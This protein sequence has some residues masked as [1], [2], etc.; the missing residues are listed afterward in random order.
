M[1]PSFPRKYNQIDST[2]LLRVPNDSPKGFYHPPLKTQTPHFLSNTL[3]VEALI[4][5][6][7]WTSLIGH[8]IYQRFN[9]PNYKT[10]QFKCEFSAPKYTSADVCSR[11]HSLSNPEPSTWFHKQKQKFFWFSLLLF[12]FLRPS[13]NSFTCNH[14]HGAN[15][16]TLCKMQWEL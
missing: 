1:P 7:K 8:W 13:R 5:S 12:Y 14:S 15:T 11:H 10:A 4:C 2:V 3:Q 9:V 16:A 6:R